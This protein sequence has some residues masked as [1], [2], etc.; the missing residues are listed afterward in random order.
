MLLMRGIGVESAVPLVRQVFRSLAVDHAPPLE[1]Q[2]ALRPRPVGLARVG[3][4]NDGHTALSHHLVGLRLPVLCQLVSE[5]SECR[6]DR[7]K[8][9]ITV[10]TKH[11]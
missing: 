1:T 5:R 4:L 11:E 8:M 10:T 6:T 2:V 9:V 3:R 7:N